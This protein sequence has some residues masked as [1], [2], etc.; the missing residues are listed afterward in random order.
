MRT[1][2]NKIKEINEAILEDVGIKQLL[3][4]KIKLL[5]KLTPKY[6]VDKEVNTMTPILDKNELEILDKIDLLLKYRK[7]QI[8]E[9]FT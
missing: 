5:N 1:N 8:K 9:N 3:D 6:L 7:E 2:F 4:R